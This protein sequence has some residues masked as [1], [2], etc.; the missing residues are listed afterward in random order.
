M[1]MPLFDPRLLFAVSWQVALAPAQDFF[2]MLDSRPREKQEPETPVPA[3]E[4][5]FAIKTA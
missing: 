1:I 4:D 3:D 5:A 2:A